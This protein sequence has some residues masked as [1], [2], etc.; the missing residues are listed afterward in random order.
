MHYEVYTI[1]NEGIPACTTV[2][3]DGIIHS[4]ID[5]EDAVIAAMYIVDG[6]VIQRAV[7]SIHVEEPRHIT[8]QP[9]PTCHHLILGSHCTIQVIFQDAQGMPLRFTDSIEVVV[10]LFIYSF[11]IEF[12][13]LKKKRTYI[14]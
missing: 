14:E 13:Q 1:S 7:A 6:V 8:L 2:S 3:R 9:E 5:K 12:L 10:S 11:L 4:C